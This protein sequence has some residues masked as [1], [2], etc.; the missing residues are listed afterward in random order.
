M[1]LIRDEKELK[2]LYANTP[3]SFDRTASTLKGKS[4]YKDYMS[5]ISALVNILVEWPSNA[6]D[7][8]SLISFLMSSDWDSS[9][10]L[11]KSS[12]NLFGYTNCVTTNNCS[13]DTANL[14]ENIQASGIDDEAKKVLIDRF[15][16]INDL[17]EILA[18][19]NN[20]LMGSY[21]SVES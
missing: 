5:S 20:D 1:T 10:L 14:R 12:T 17:S 13:P 8:L 15:D 21:K 7:I 19:I 11:P 3:N 6:D 2:Q 9:S 16:D 4:Y 18:E